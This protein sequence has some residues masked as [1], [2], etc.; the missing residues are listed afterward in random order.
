MPKLIFFLPIIFC[1]SCTLSLREQGMKYFEVKK[2]TE[3]ILSKEEFFENLKKSK[4]HGHML[5]E[6]NFDKLVHCA[7]LRNQLLTCVIEG[8]ASDIVKKAAKELEQAYQ[9]SEEDFLLA[10]ENILA[11]DIG[12]EFLSVQSKYQW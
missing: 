5:Y 1:T 4:E 8:Y 11:N 2:E 7:L 6:N 3:G 12:K 10:C 9:N